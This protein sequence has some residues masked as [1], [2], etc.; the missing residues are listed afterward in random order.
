MRTMILHEFL[1]VTGPVNHGEG[2][3]RDAREGAPGDEQRTS[4]RSGESGEAAA[5]GTSWG[6]HMKSCK[7]GTKNT[8]RWLMG[9]IPV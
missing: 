4:R 5:E 6:R 9:R 1:N 2:E 8:A 3:R 7:H